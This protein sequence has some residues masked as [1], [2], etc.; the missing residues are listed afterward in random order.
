MFFTF[1]NFSK[2]SIFFISIIFL[3]GVDLVSLENELWI[4]LSVGYILHATSSFLSII[5][6]NLKLNKYLKQNSIYR[7]QKVLRKD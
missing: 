3:T 7:K 6:L 2:K 1:L 4:K 5:Y